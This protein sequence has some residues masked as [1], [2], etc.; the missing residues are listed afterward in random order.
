MISLSLTLE[1]EFD[2]CVTLCYHTT[3]KSILPLAP[4][5]KVIPYHLITYRSSGEPNLVE[6]QNIF[7]MVRRYL[8][9]SYICIYTLVLRVITLTE[10]R[11]NKP[12]PRVVPNKEHVSKIRE[13]A[14][15]RLP[16]IPI[17]IHTFVRDTKVLSCL[18]S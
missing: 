10:R 4:K 11:C 5:L 2:Y 15:G 7:K 3:I 18:R 14:S 6:I 1:R 17:R 16:S 9:T 13:Q 8:R 12:T